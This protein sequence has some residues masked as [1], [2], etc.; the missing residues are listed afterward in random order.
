MVWNVWNPN[1]LSY[2]SALFLLLFWIT[3]VW[4]KGEALQEKAYFHHVY[5]WCIK[6]AYGCV[7][8]MMKIWMSCVWNVYMYFFLIETR[9]KRKKI[10]KYDQSQ[11]TCIMNNVHLKVL[12]TNKGKYEIYRR[13]ETI[14]WHPPV[15]ALWHSGVCSGLVI[16]GTVVRVR[17][18]CVCP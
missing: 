7:C 4:K 5:L 1:H 16:S 2:I 18:R 6:C 9:W 3:C 15:G 14:N 17:S 13:I 12:K 10:W 8:I 11:S